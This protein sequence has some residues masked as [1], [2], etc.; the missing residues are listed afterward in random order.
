MVFFLVG[1]A[2]K[3]GDLAGAAL[4]FRLNLLTQAF[5]LG[6]LPAVG[7]GLSRVLAAGGMHPALADGVLIL[8]CL[9]T[10]V[11]MCVILTQSAEGARI[12][13]NQLQERVQSLGT[14]DMPRRVRFRINPVLRAVGHES[15][16]PVD[17]GRGRAKTF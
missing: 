3:L 1:L 7:V 2:I 11:N 6:V 10:T 17:S 15:S 16:S 5:S 14:S 4:N 9:P 12:C 13:V 8:M